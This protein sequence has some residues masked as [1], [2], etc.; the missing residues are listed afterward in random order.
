[1]KTLFTLF[2]VTLFS[3]SCLFAQDAGDAAYVAGWTAPL[4]S[5][6]AA[7]PA[8]KPAKMTASAT[9]VT[10]FNAA[11][12]NFDTEWA[13]IAG[14]E[15][16]IGGDGHRLGLAASEKGASDFTGS[17]KVAADESNIYILLK[18]TDD[19]VTGN[20]TVEVA[21]AP[22]DS[23]NAPKLASLPQAWY[24]RY[25]QFGAYKATFK[26]TGFDAAM[27]IDGSTGNI[28]WGGTNDI[29]SNNLYIDDRSAAGSTTVKQ[30]ITI[31]F[32][33]LTGEARPDFD[34]AIWK[35]LNSG[36]GIS[37]DLKVN[38]TD[39]DD[40]MNDKNEV[41]PAE[42]WWNAVNNDSY[43]L[44]AYA[45][46]L[47]VGTISGIEKTVLANSIFQ[48]VTPNLILFSKT[49]NVTVYNILGSQIVSKRNVNQIDLSNLNRGIYIIRANNE[50]LKVV[51]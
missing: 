27:M 6:F 30:I 46:Y 13:K 5:W 12:A 23:I 50:S 34:L 18:Y 4:P 8:V 38:D 28:N 40:A 20:E 41:K 25:Q 15:N 9:M 11:S 29:L 1:M 21:W 39:P 14:A 17:F 24:A 2:L 3:V 35:A 42:Y 51:H 7:L 43:A 48:T 49:A 44:T 45:G 22:Y 26:K 36:K 33:A 47:K 31:G 10:N 37:L 19:N 16:V 32:A